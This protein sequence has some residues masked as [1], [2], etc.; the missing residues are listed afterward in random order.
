MSNHFDFDLLGIGSGPAG[1]RAAIQAAK[2][3]KRVGIIE[4][5]ECAGGVCVGLGTIPS[6]TFREA[7]I[8]FIPINYP[9]LAECYKVAALNA[10]TNWRSRRK[11]WLGM[12]VPKMNRGHCQARPRQPSSVQPFWGDHF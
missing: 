9:T 8:S 7:V 5:E 11:V 4:R 2:F 1:Q 10:L 12:I 6:K 3:Q